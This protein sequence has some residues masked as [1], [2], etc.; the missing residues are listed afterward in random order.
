M[1][2]LTDLFGSEGPKQ[3]DVDNVRLN[4]REAESERLR[5][6][7]KQLM[8]DGP[9]LEAGVDYAETGLVSFG[10]DEDTANA[11]GNQRES[12]ERNAADI[13]DAA[14][15][16]GG[17]SHGEWLEY[18]STEGLLGE[19]GIDAQDAE[20]LSRWMNE[21]GASDHNYLFK[22]DFNEGADGWNWDAHINELNQE[23][24]REF[25][26]LVEMYAPRI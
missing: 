4:A 3:R 2:L 21:A 10:T 18:L 22:D 19:G 26:A 15:P 12:T 9:Q 23:R 16:T 14:D 7:T 6:L 8:W 1:G 11:M 24:L 20:W 17:M 13:A 5:G 25:Q